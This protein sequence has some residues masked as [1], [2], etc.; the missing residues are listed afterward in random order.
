MRLMVTDLFS[1]LKCYFVLCICHYGSNPGP[2]VS[3][4]Q[5]PAHCIL[6]WPTFAISAQGEGVILNPDI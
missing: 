5:V 4:S 6:G 3:K 2:Q 1:A